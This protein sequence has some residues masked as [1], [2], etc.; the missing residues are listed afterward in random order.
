MKHIISNPHNGA[1]IEHDGVTLAPGYEVEVPVRE[2]H[3]LRARF[4]FLLHRT[5][6][7]KPSKNPKSVK[8]KRKLEWHTHNA[9]VDENP[10]PDEV[11]HEVES[12]KTAE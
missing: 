3:S 7:G 8:I 10:Q 1:P 6:D 9:G 12:D 5:E 2:A 11:R 4:G